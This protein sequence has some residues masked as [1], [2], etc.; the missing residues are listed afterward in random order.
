MLRAEASR[1][2]VEQLA[3]VDRHAGNAPDEL[4]VGEVVLVA[5]AWVGVHLQGVVIPEG[6]GGLNEELSG[7]VCQGA[8]RLIQG[9][10]TMT[11]GLAYEIRSLLSW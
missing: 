6:R 4:E 9:N 8:E 2:T 1:F 3:V 7:I 11:Q 5:E 10:K